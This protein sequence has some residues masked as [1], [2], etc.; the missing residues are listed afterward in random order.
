[1]AQSSMTEL[2]ATPIDTLAP[3][4]Y[5]RS[6]ARRVKR[7]MPGFTLTAPVCAALFASRIVKPS[8]VTSEA[9]TIIQAARTVVPAV[10]LPLIVAP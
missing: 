8:T 1:M 5:A 7:L 9:F 3:A 10:S 4:A 6:H 2:L